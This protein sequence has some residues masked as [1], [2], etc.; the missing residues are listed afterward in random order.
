[1]SLM[2]VVQATLAAGAA[3]AAEPLSEQIPPV[4][5]ARLDGGPLTIEAR[6][7]QEN[8]VISL[9]DSQGIEYAGGRAC[10]QVDLKNGKRLLPRAVIALRDGDHITVTARSEEIELTHDLTVLPGKDGFREQIRVLNT[11]S[12]RLEI[13]DYRFGLRR[14]RAAKGELRA[15]AVPFRRQAD[16]RLRVARRRPNNPNHL[17]AGSR[18]RPSWVSQSQWP[19]AGQNQ[20]CPSP[21]LVGV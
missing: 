16:G 4:R 18:S 17:T 8:V 1:M 21:T 12:K 14:P 6:Q 19:N 9:Q 10:Y 7:E 3:G 5:S 2:V 15:V 13:D 20:E 11:G